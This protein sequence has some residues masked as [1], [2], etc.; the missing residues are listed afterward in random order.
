M[1]Q[2]PAMMAVSRWCFRHWC[3]EWSTIPQMG[4]SWEVVRHATCTATKLG[5]RNFPKSLFQNLFKVYSVFFKIRFNMFYRE[6]AS[7]ESPRRLR[8]L[9][10]AGWSQSW[11]LVVA[12][13]DD[14]RDLMGARALRREPPDSKSSCRRCWLRQSGSGWHRHT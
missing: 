6:A 8:S 9:P 1:R 3:H 12:D 13:A 5:Q 10:I 4:P 7:C 11:S 14:A 2:E